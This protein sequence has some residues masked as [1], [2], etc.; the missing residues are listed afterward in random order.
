[1][2]RAPSLIVAWA[3]A[4]PTADNVVPWL[5]KRAVGYQADSTGH[6]GREFQ[7]A[8]M[9][10]S[11]RVRSTGGR[12]PVSDDPRIAARGTA[13]NLSVR[14]S[15]GTRRGRVR[16][17]SAPK[18]PAPPALSPGARYRD[19]GFVG[20]PGG[21][22]HRPHLAPAPKRCAHPEGRSGRAGHRTA[23]IRR[24]SDYESSGRSGRCASMGARSA[25][26]LRWAGNSSSPAG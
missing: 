1:M 20:T 9:S 21:S 16:C 24:R 5:G 18:P 15:L 2:L 4:S 12:C 25:V 6:W 13:G 10:G 3:V 17:V 23:S 8:R 19:G 14:R 7:I 22:A 26:G 11:G